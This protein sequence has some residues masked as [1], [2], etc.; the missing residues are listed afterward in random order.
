MRAR[1]P[2]KTIL[3]G[4]HAVVYGQ[5][6]L[7]MAVPCYAHARLYRS[8]DKQEEIR[9]K[10]VDLDRCEQLLPDTL[11]DFRKSC[12]Q[13]H[14]RF[15]AGELSIERVLETPADLYR[16]AIALLPELLPMLQGYTIE[17]GSQIPIGSGMGSSAATVAA[18]LRLLAGFSEQALSTDTLI[19]RVT[20]CEMLQH[21]RSSGLDPALCIEGGIARFQQGELQKL[22]L[23]LGEGW[24]LLDTG[25]PLSSTGQCGAVVR[26]QHGS[27]D[28]WSEFGALTEQLTTALSN[29]AGPQIS[30]LL[31]A[32]QRLLEQIGV[33]PEPVQRLIRQI[34]ACGA[35]AKVSGA[36]AVTGDSAGLVLVYGPELT[37]LQLDSLALPWQRLSMDTLGAQFEKSFDKPFEEK[38]L[39]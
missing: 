24:Y 20:E 25:R 17:L 11:A 15:I 18:L 37:P 38:P 14:R 2:A 12:E 1:A 23:Q 4:E 22:P 21:G 27:S 6:A 28:I 33:V 30:Q 13:R 10:L 29:N 9:L 19:A 7:A 26:Q 36:G 3:S 8:A 34:E 5:P 35:V 32:N 31:R 39:D 16:Y